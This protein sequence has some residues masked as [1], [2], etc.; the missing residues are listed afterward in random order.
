MSPTPLRRRAIVA[1]A[2]F[3]VLGTTCFAGT[4]SA[5]TAAEPVSTPVPI[6]TPEGVVF[7]YILNA[8]HA[9]Q[10]QVNLVSR[11]VEKAGGV[12]VQAWPEIG[13]VVAHSNRAAFRADVTAEARGALESV[14]ASRTVGVTEGTPD[15]GVDPVGQERPEV[16]ARAE[17]GQR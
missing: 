6:V 7:S 8:K 4:A 5:A 14:G 3:A 9:N 17:E 10:G 16:P 12:V 2:S 11:A 1:V 15:G 13:V